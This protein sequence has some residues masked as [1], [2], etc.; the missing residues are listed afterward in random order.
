MTNRILCAAFVATLVAACSSG[1]GTVPSTSGGSSGGGTTGGNN[2]SA[3][4]TSEAPAPPSGAK[5]ALLWQV[6]S[7]SPDYMYSQA[8][9]ATQNDK[10]T[11]ALST[12]PPAEAL[13]AGKIGIAF[14]T[15]F[16][17]ATT[18]PDGKIDSK[19]FEGTMLSI[20]PDYAVIY[21]ATT[22]TVLKNGWD[23]SFPQGYACGKCV[24]AETGFDTYVVVDCSE[25]RLV[26]ASSKPKVCNWT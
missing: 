17:A 22:E 3:V 1:S 11:L 13:N 26:P 16:D 20:S 10:A 18:P 7:G 24:R 2:L 4:A 9:G 8:A 14:V 12:T 5:V 21:R 19:T 23:A 6:S 15:V 25:I